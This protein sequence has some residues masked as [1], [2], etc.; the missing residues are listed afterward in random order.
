MLWMV[1]IAAR[2]IADSAFLP[3]GVW[4][5]LAVLILFVRRATAEAMMPAQSRTNSPAV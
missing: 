4:T 2:S 3:L 5:M 1:P